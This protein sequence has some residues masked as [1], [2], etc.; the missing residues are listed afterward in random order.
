[1]V[2]CWLDFSED[3]VLL[4]ST[5]PYR[6]I[7]AHQAVRRAIRGYRSSHEERALVLLVSLTQ[8]KSRQE[9]CARIPLVRLSIVLQMHNV[10]AVRRNARTHPVLAAV[11]LHLAGLRGHSRLLAAPA[12]LA[13][14]EDVRA[15]AHCM[16]DWWVSFFL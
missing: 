6:L 14:A 10:A 7:V 2:S 13:F 15:K 8:V 9:R 3:A 1:M 12:A 5:Y 16:R 11:L 4:L